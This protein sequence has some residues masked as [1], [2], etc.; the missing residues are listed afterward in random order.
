MRF[1]ALKPTITKLSKIKK[2]NINEDHDNYDEKYNKY[3]V[4]T[5]Y[6]GRSHRKLNMTQLAGS[7]TVRHFIR[8]A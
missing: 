5:L 4:S 3:Q 2:Q 6:F 8:R 1:A 7:H